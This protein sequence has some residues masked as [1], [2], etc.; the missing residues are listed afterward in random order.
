MRRRIASRTR[1]SSFGPS[2]TRRHDHTAPGRAMTDLSSCRSLRAQTPYTATPWERTVEPCRTG[3]S[4]GGLD[5]GPP[6]GPKPR[7]Q[8]ARR[9]GRGRRPCCSRCS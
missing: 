9:D 6:V 5:I 2:A 4:A 8:S 1:C 7:R 3:P